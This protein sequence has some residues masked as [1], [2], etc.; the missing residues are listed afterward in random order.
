MI[1]IRLIQYC[2]IMGKSVLD[3]D[4]MYIR[5]ESNKIRG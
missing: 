5:V 3:A 2:L 1:Y 4:G